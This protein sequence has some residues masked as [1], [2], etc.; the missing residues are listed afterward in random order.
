MRILAAI[1]L[2]A[3]PPPTPPLPYLSCT[4]EGHVPYVIICRD[5]FGQLSVK[6]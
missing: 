2:A 4:T 3:L 5:S 1:I 6:A